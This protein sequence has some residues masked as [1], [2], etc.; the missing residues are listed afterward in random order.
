MAA[1]ASRSPLPPPSE[2]GECVTILAIDGG[3]IRCLIPGTIL[4]FL[5]SELLVHL[6]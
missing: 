4:E 1:A 2:G 3:G 6:R 5:E